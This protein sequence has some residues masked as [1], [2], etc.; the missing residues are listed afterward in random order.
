MLPVATAQTAYLAPLAAIS[1]TQPYVWSVSSGALPP[2]VS[3]TASGTLSGTPT[4]GGTF[5][6]TLTVTDAAKKT[7]SA[8]YQIVVRPALTAD[9]QNLPPATA[10]QSYAAALSATGGTSPYA[11]TLGGSAAPAGLIFSRTGVISGIPQT[12]GSYSFTA[13]V[14][15][16]STPSPVSAFQTYSLTVLAPLTITTAS[17]PPTTATLVYAATFAAANGTPP[18]IWSLAAGSLPPGLGIAPNG[19]ISGT[20]TGTGSFSFVAQVV[21]SASPVR[22]TTKAFTITGNSK[23]AI[24]STAPA[25]SAGVAVN[26]QLT[27][28]GGTPAYNW[29]LASGTLP[30]GISLTPSGV[31]SGTPTK[32]GSFAATITVTDAQPQSASAV[33]NFTVASGA[34]P[35]LSI[36]PDAQTLSPATQVPLSISLPSAAPSDITGAL[37]LSGSN[38][39][40]LAFLT[41][42]GATSRSVAFRIATGSAQATFPNGTPVL[43][44]GTVAASVTLTATLDNTNPAQTA[45]ATNRLLPEQPVISSASAAINGQTLT[46][47][48]SGYSTTREAQTATFRF[49]SGATSSAPFSLD[50]SGMFN[51]WFNSTASN[52]SGTF[53]YAQPF[54]VTNPASITTIE[55]SLTNSVG[56]SSTVQLSA[57]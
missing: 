28:S 24:T 39:S 16:S 37:S 46:I 2:G 45:T 4:T 34:V 43:Q 33:F 26:S 31:L 18:Y 3:V 13:T 38:D 42:S 35:P 19:A 30:N 14:T 44:T 54:T 5:P 52:G 50:V 6:F 41:P 8:N 10:G 12:P 9:L 7:A 29:T 17:L 40:A 47:T 1:G 11:W 32:S 25:L 49:F 56:T 21:D 55:V 48:L 57:K 27:A 36:H 22:L 53:H 23:L 51:S 20:P 15:D